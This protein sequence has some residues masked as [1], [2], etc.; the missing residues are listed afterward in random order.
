MTLYKQRRTNS[1]RT[2]G[3]PEHQTQRAVFSN[4]G[5]DESRSE[6]RKSHSKQLREA[7]VKSVKKGDYIE[8]PH[9]TSAGKSE[10]F[11]AQVLQ[12]VGGEGLECSYRVRW[13]SDDTDEVID[14]SHP[15]VRIM[16]AM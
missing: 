3:D 5:R 12:P 7:E 15:R 2:S 6:R 1:S 11:R 4:Q 9:Q 13:L 8:E 16:G 14:V 10:W